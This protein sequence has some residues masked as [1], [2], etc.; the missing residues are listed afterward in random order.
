[1]SRQF[2]RLRW[3]V[4]ISL[5]AAAVIASM[6]LA[7]LLRF[8]F[9]VP[10]SQI[11]GFFPKGLLYA[12]VYLACIASRG[13]ITGLWRYVSLRDAVRIA[14]GCALAGVVLYVANELAGGP[15]WVPRS[16]SLL[17]CGITFLSLCGLRIMVRLLREASPA[18]AGLKGGGERLIL[19][20]AGDAGFQ[21]A[22]ELLTKRLN[23]YSLVGFLD[24]DEAKQGTT[25]LGVPVLGTIS[26]LEKV[27]D[28]HGVEVAIIAMPSAGGRIIRDLQKECVRLNIQANSLPGMSSIINGTVTISQVRP[29]SVEDLLRRPETQLDLEQI[30]KSLKGRSVM[31]TGA[32][33][34]IGS[35]LCRQVARF[36]PGRLLLVDQGE[37][38]LYQIEVWLRDNF[39][40]LRCVP[41]LASICDEKL[42]RTHFDSG[43]DV[44]LHAAAYKHVPLLEA[45]PLQALE[46]NVRG[47]RVIAKLAIET[48]VDSFVMVSTDKAVRPSSIM[49][50]SKRICELLLQGL[51][52]E[53]KGTSFKTVRFG[54][55]LG[56]NGSV[57]PR[58]QEQIRRGGPVT[59]THPDITRFFMTIPEASQLILQAATMG[60]GGEIFI[61]EMGDPVKIVDLARDLI[62]LSGLIPDEDIS[63][64]YTGLRPGEKMYEELL[65]DEEELENTLYSSIL[66][67]KSVLSDPVSFVKQ[68]DRLISEA[69]TSGDAIR[70]EFSSIIEQHHLSPPS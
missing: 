11:A 47:T 59:V 17:T 49:G 16:V 29:V 30:S 40:Y 39:P 43:V 35:E 55:V 25:I 37:T 24:D 4:I 33:G 1:M 13:A 52:A 44:V 18:E 54:T 61:L 50:A 19:L 15:L 34:S 5:Q 64:E 62:S 65:L 12:G 41:I 6:G 51:A 48:E 38:P 21:I 23:R 70:K 45:N 36:S 27:R 67:G 66:L 58:F 7:M 68:V 32:G 8:E 31:V 10:E 9:S 3:L 22:R 26:S 2:Y 63:I 14:Q 57:I 46:N 56:S 20:G 69:P 42:L 28:T 60:T 53:A